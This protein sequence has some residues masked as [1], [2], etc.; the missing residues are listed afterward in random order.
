MAL[1]L[2]ESSL[3]IGCFS[4]LRPIII[5]AIKLV[6]RLANVRTLKKATSHSCWTI[7]QAMVL[8]CL[9]NIVHRS[10]MILM[11]ICNPCDCRTH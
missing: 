2:G 5:V 6:M 10:V 3:G 4:L 7:E 1:V 11:P 8:S 9:I